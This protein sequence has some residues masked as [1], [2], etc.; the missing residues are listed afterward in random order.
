MPYLTKGIMSTVPI[1]RGGIGTM[2]TDCYLRIYYDPKV[3]GMWTLDECSGVILHEI[4]HII[5]RHANRAKVKIGEKPAEGIHKMWNIAADISI[6]Q[7]LRECSIILP[8]D[9]MYETTF[10]FPSNLSTEEYYD[11]ICQLPKQ[12]VPSDQMGPGT[13]ES[14]GSASDG[15]VRPWEAGPPGSTGPGGEENPYGLGDYERKRLERVVANDIAEAARSRGNVP[16]MLA[17]IAHDILKPR[18]DPRK[19]ILSEVKY[20]LNCTKGFGNSTWMLPSRRSQPGGLRLPKS[21]CPVPR[22]LLI[23]DTSGSMNKTDL[24]LCRGV[25][26]DVLKSL[27][28]PEGVRVITGDTHMATCQK[29]FSNA[30]VEMVG[31]GGTD[32]GAI[33]EQAV[34]DHKD[35]DVIIVVTDGYTPWPRSPLRPKC[36]AL[37]TQKR[38][39]GVPS[40]MRTVYIHPDGE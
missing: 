27:P 16:G 14:S 12:K 23:F 3:F 31:G 22:P 35:V 18:F 4:M 13:G 38:S 2:A 25:L 9:A 29:A 6:N 30:Q 1:E 40:W 10:G 21:V 33:M 36:L 15:V 34:Q 32:M 7:V 37:I 24:A 17:R 8:K 28:C 5:M 39:D 19:E 26:E 20:A 11:L